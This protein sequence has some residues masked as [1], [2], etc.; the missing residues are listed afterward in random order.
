MRFLAI[1]LA[2]TV[3]MPIRAQEAPLVPAPPIYNAP[4][5]APEIYSELDWRSPSG[6]T[7]AG[8][9]YSVAQVQKLNLRLNYLENRCTT[10]CIQATNAATKADLGSAKALWLAGGI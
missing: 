4:A 6:Q 10:E 3:A 9:W 5:Q 7:T 1:I 8:Y 2:A